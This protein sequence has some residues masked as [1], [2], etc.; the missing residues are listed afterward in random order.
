MLG[1]ELEALDA[2]TLTVEVFLIDQICCQN[3]FARAFSSFLGIKPGLKNHVV[4]K[5]RFA[6]L[7]IK[8]YD[9]TVYCL[10]DCQNLKF[11]DESLRQLMQIKKNLQ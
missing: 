6:L 1:T 8:C 3:K 4:R 5:A 7:S 9:A 10:R 2:T 11:T